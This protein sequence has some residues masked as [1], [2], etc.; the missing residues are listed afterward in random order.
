MKKH[1]IGIRMLLV[2]GDAQLLIHG[3]KLVSLFIAYSDRYF[4]MIMIESLY[5][6]I[7]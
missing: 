4:M 1:G 2:K 5:P 6:P 7:A 3:G